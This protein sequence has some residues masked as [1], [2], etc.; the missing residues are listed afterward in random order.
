MDNETLDITRMITENL[1]LQGYISATNKRNT[2]GLPQFHT[3]GVGNSVPDIFFYHPEYK[4]EIFNPDFVPNPN[5]VIRAGFIELKSGKHLSD[6][7]DGA[8][9]V[10]TYYRYFISNKAKVFLEGSQIHNVDCFVLATD[11]SP[12]GMI[13]KGDDTLFPLPV[14]YISEKYDILISPF[15][16]MIHSLIRYFQK[17]QREQLR[18]RKMLIPKNKLNVEAGIMISKIPYD[19]NLSISYEYYTWLGN[20]IKPVVAKSRYSEEYTKV[21]VKILGIKDKA[22][23][24][25]TKL[26]KQ[27]WIPRSLIKSSMHST[28]LIIEQWTDLEIIRW[29]HKNNESLFGIT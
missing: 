14:S 20:R 3:K 22:L 1:S 6:L 23:N 18:K 13:Y 5:P 11:W 29:F 7:L 28:Q 19:E 4:D 25:E 2:L 9:Q 15:T 24:I 17:I 27:L 10:A 16:L 12:F 8:S 26:K 21:R